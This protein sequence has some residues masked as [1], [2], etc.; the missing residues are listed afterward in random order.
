MQYRTD[1]IV[2]RRIGV[3]EDD[4]NGL[5]G[6]HGRIPYSLSAPC[7]AEGVPEEALWGRVSGM[8]TNKIERI[9]TF[10]PLQKEGEGGL[11]FV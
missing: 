9:R 11:G 6:F 5:G 3:D 7:S 2:E 8:L 10:P 1:R 4:V